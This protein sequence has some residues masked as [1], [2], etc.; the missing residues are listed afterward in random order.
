MKRLT[1]IICLAAL[2]FVFC[3]PLPCAAQQQRDDAS[4]RSAA[5][6]KQILIGV[7]VEAEGGGERQGMWTQAAT[8]LTPREL[9]TLE[10]L[11]VEE[12]KKQEGVKTVP[13]DY[14]DDHIGIVVVAAKVRNGSAGKWYYIASSVVVIAAKKGT[15]ELV[16][17]DVLADS[18]LASLAA[19][20]GAQFVSVRFR[21]VTGLWK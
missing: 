6:P 20:I 5:Q 4:S 8:D 14:E 3:G 9:K 7:K 11:V 19:S 1:A 21:A 15:D 12:M 18:D 16:T 2:A 17:H 10:R 13:F